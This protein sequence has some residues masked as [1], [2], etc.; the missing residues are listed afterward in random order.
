MRSHLS[1]RP[2]LERADRV[3]SRLQAPPITHTPKPPTDASTALRQPPVK[4]RSAHAPNPCTKQSMQPPWLADHTQD[5]TLHAEMSSEAW[6][7]DHGAAAIAGLLRI[8][9]LDSMS[10]NLSRTGPEEV[11]FWKYDILKLPPAGMPANK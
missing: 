5:V 9:D 11:T 3:L 6:G 1:G 10:A 4:R 8:T 7:T 2:S